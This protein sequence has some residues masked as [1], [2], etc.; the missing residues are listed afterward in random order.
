MEQ[1]SKRKIAVVAVAVIIIAVAAMSIAALSKDDDKTNGPFTVIDG[2]GRKV[3]IESSNR[4]ASTSSLVT[5]FI[6]SL[7]EYSKLAGVTNDINPLKVQDYLI[8]IPDDGFPQT[9]VSGLNNGT[10]KD[11]GPMYLISAESI[12]LC[13][14]DLVIMGG[15]FN[16]DATISQLEG[17]GIPVVICKDNSSIDNIYFNIE[18]VGKVIEKESEAQKLV[19]QMRSAIKK[20]VDWTKSLDIEGPSVGSFISLSTGTSGSYACGSQ[21]I[22]G[23][24]LI[25]MLG[26]T[27][28][29]S[30]IA[31]NYE[32]VSKESIATFDPD[33]IISGSHSSTASTGELELIKNDPVLKKVS[34]I[35]NDRLYATF[36]T[37]SSAYTS[38]S[39]GFVNTV[40]FMAMFMYEDQLNFDMNNYMDNDYE[41]YL[42]LF[43]NQINT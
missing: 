10:L 27:N 42:R 35:K 9:I 18:L 36:G 16:S 14:P 33:V 24:K 40:A 26:G 25:E 1:N 34:A 37:S 11:I 28:A 19:N 21:Y 29:F 20:I 8:G 38:T 43:W 3:N 39:H 30:G 31:G 7:G 4:I 22:T 23:T 17:M 2:L 41:K 13:N 32:V 12:L 6:C 15:Y 5:E